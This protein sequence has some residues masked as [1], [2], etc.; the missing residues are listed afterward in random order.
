M[1]KLHTMSYD[2]IITGQNEESK[3]LIITI[4]DL[5]DNEA[6]VLAADITKF[7]LNRDYQLKKQAPDILEDIFKVGKTHAAVPVKAN[8]DD[9]IVQDSG[10]DCKIRGNY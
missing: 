3:R 10:I 7:L 5:K 6:A 1:T 9:G 2:L 4:G 8:V